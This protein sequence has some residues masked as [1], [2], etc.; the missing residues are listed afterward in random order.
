MKIVSV[1][2]SENKRGKYTVLFDDEAEIKVSAIQIADFGLYSGREFEDEEY[3]DLLKSVA[4]GASKA[5][6]LRILGKRTL[7]AGE[8][9][10][11]LESKGVDAG[12]AGQT[13]EWLENIGAINDTEYAAMIVRH[14]VPKGYGL[15]RIKDELY[16]RGVPR[17]IWDEALQGAEGFEDAAQDYLMKKLRGSSGKDDLRRAADALCR[18]GFSYSEASDA[19]RRYLEYIEDE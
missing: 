3:E 13:V 4:L 18:R 5:K 6:S 12:T 15:A 10:K 16:K 8:V 7:S 19:V 17:D 2:G 11:R 9:K 14:Y 1:T